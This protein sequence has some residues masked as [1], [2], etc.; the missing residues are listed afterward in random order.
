MDALIFIGL[1]GLI[2]LGVWLSWYLKAKRRKELALAASQLGLSFAPVDPFGCLGYPFALL[3]RGD[4]RGVE[5]VLWGTWQGMPVRAFDYWYYEEQQTSKGR[6]SRSYRH[7]SCAVT[8]IEAACSPLRLE[9]ENLLTRLADHLALRDLEFE[10]EEFNRRFNVKGE[11]RRFAHAFV[12]ARMM[13]WLLTVPGEFSFEVCGRWLLCYSRRRAPF[14]LV[15]LL[16]TLQGFRER[17]PRVVFD[18]YPL[19]AG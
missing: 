15:P 16:G 5:N 13:D 3:R 1:L 17:V 9:R 7:F 10:S 18:L 2:L 4:G 8:E 6:R 12:D 19:A 14:D 11:D